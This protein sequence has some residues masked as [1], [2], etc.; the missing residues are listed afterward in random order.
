MNRR[1]LR[2]VTWALVLASLPVCAQEPPPYGRLVIASTS[3]WGDGLSGVVKNL[4]PGKISSVVIQ[5]NPFVEDNP[6]AWGDY[7]TTKVVTRDLG[8]LEANQETSFNLT[9]KFFRLPP[10]IFWVSLTTNHDVSP[11]TPTCRGHAACQTLLR[12]SRLCES[13]SER[14]DFVSERYHRVP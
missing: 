13:E 14:S 8:T 3:R 2:V 10:R 9:G 11:Y 4:G 12:R 7:G 6:A 5:A 1:V